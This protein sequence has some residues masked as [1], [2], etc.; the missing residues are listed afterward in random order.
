L[1]LSHALLTLILF[2]YWIYPAT[3]PWCAL[4]ACTPWVLV[5]LLFSFR[6]TLSLTSLRSC[7]TAG[8]SSPFCRITIPLKTQIL[9]HGSIAVPGSPLYA[10]PL[11]LIYFL[12]SYSAGSAALCLCYTKPLSRNLQCRSLLNIYSFSSRV[13]WLGF[14]VCYLSVNAMLLTCTSIS[15][16]LAAF[17][18]AFLSSL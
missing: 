1:P 15:V 9:G 4:H 17:L 5:R 14:Y 10:M 2:I 7:A 6:K 18:H 16:S 8:F 3:V 11:F 12:P 13:R